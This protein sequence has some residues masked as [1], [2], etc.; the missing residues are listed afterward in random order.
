MDYVW[1]YEFQDYR[2]ASVA[3]ENAFTDYNEKRPHSSVD[4]LP[5]RVFRVADQLCIKVYNNL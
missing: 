4:Y 1:P 3:I 5:P 2:E